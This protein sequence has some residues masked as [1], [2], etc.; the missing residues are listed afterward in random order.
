MSIST[1]EWALEL[2]KKENIILIC[3]RR[4][5][6]VMRIGKVGTRRGEKNQIRT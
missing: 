5:Q 6:K 1:M 2:R 3:V 4:I